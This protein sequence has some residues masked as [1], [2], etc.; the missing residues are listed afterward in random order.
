[1]KE[2]INRNSADTLTAFQLHSIPRNSENFDFQFVAMTN[3]KIIK[4]HCTYIMLE[5]KK[6]G[7][8][9]IIWKKYS[10]LKFREIHL[11][12]CSALK[13][14]NKGNSKT[15]NTFYAKCQ[16]KIMKKWEKSHNNVNLIRLRYWKEYA[17][18]SHSLFNKL[19][20]YTYLALFHC[21]RIE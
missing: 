19:M 6:N 3:K 10:I 18:W 1:M 12:H 8:D 15:K 20:T 13:K 7:T 14:W 17:R 21:Q 11:N 16:T 5:L 4:N 9:N 2:P